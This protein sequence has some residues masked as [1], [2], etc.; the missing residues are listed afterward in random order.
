MSLLRGFVPAHLWV[1]RERVRSRDGCRAA[2]RVR[3]SPMSLLQGD[4][5]AEDGW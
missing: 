5:A 3:A 1:E 2:E 4:G